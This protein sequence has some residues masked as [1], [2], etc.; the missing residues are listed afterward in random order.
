MLYAKTKDIL[1]VKQQMGHRKLETTLIYTQLL[2]ITDEEYTCKTATT[3]KQASDLI[4][5]GFEYVTTTPDA[6]MLFR[7]RK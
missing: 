7:K 3:A 2:D 5:A 1:L 6:L 4:E